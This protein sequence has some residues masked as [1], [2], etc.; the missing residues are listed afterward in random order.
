LTLWLGLRLWL[1]L[2]LRL[3]LWLRVPSGPGMVEVGQGVVEEGVY[4]DRVE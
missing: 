1:R 2:G 3:W 4:L